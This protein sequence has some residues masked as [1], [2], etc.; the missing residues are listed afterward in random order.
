MGFSV[1][2]GEL[3]RLVTQSFYQETEKAQILQNH[4]IIAAY[5]RKNLRDYFCATSGGV[6]MI[7]QARSL[8]DTRGQRWR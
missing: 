1:S 7:L 6:K 4:K 3:V 5:K 8:T 2:T